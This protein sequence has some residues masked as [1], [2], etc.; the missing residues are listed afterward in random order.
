MAHYKGIH[1][2]VDNADRLNNGN[3][4]AYVPVYEAFS[5]F[6]VKDFINNAVMRD[7]KTDNERKSF[8]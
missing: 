3:S 5:S 6:Y 4:V 2:I 8:R 7:A 1:G